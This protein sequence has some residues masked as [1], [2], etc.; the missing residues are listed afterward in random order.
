MPVARRLALLLVIPLVATLVFGMWAVVST[1]RQVTAAERLR[2]LVAAST[3]AG[4]A[5]A[6]LDRERFLATQ[7]LTADSRV[8]PLLEQF[9]RSD[10]AIEGYRQRRSRLTDDRDTTRLFGHF[11]AQLALLPAFREQ[12]RGRSMS[13]SAV[14]ARYRVAVAHGLTVRES[15]GQVGG[16]DNDLADRL[17]VAAA[18]SRASE[19]AGTREESVL[20]ATA[21]VMTLAVQQDLAV[22]RA[23][24]D[25][26]LL[27]AGQRSPQQWRV[28]LDQA[29][30]GP[31]ILTAQ[32][33][34]DEVA[35]ASV[36]SRS[37]VDEGAWTRA[38]TD[39]R[40][41]L[42][43][44]RSRIDAEIAADVQ[45]RREGQ[46]T[47]T[48]VLGA[49]AVALVALAAVTT[50]RQGR[51]LTRRLRRVRD[52]VSGMAEHDLP[53][54]V[55]RASTADPTDPAAVMSPA[56]AAL[57][58][59]ARRDEID[60][61]MAAFD[62]LALVTHHVATDL[63]RQRRVT[64]AAVEA[65]GR[66]C[67]SMT[68]RLLD[69]LDTAERDEADAATLSTLFALDHLAAQ[70][71]HHTQ[72]LLVLS[73]RSVGTVRSEPASLV[74][75]A[76]AAQGLIQ[77]Y[78]RVD[79][80]VI[81]DRI[82]VPPAMVDDLVHLV[83]SLLDNATR[84]NPGNALITGHLLGDR[85]I[86]QIVDAGTGITPQLMARLNAELA[87]PAPQIDVEHIRRQGLATVA[88]LAAAHGLS[89]RLLPG[90]PRGTVAEVEIP[91]ERLLIAPAPPAELPAPA[92]AGRRA[93]GGTPASTLTLPIP[94]PPRQPAAIP[95]PRP[96]E[97]PLVGDSPTQP[98]PTISRKQ[99]AMQREAT[100]VFNEAARRQ[101]LP[102]PWF[103]DGATVHLHADP[104]PATTDEAARTISG[105][106]VRQPMAVFTPPPPPAPE[107][108]RRPS[109]RQADVAAAYQR[110]LGRHTPAEG[111]P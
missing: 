12:I 103:D 39:R 59:G 36:G 85:V 105:L 5:L 86:L 90:Q 49:V 100:P 31:Q 81:N 51:T 77:E 45:R 109:T 71:L 2:S 10:A 60:D 96:P 27:T 46:W 15:V 42:H 57:L 30:T 14:L 54:I 80:G 99:W 104:G 50:V 78:L 89:V 66:R 107:P 20:A 75:V 17:R 82:Q 58:A 18:V 73:G 47:S 13:R 69:A 52:A 97:T 1:G 43:A 32:R 3:A 64:S 21:G 38:A 41:R 6:E 70:L 22:T 19:A 29:L 91:A 35:R 55:R 11:D 93:P 25:E 101:P 92:I 98:L 79:L 65:V 61:V 67:Q 62:S 88:V 26:A 111:Q 8:D 94:A 34:D 23:A 37:R 33:L 95:A 16:A 108:P 28:W 68:R 44:L 9:S 53:E 48:L 24:Y 4:D 63:A 72:S 102:S 110:G 56:P 106:P 76:Q 83:A 74:T 7:S 84:Y 87:A 40:E